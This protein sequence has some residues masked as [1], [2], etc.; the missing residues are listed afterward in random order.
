MKRILTVCVMLALAGGV[1]GMAAPVHAQ[2]G[3]DPLV[4]NGDFEQG[5][6]FWTVEQ[7]CT[8]CRLAL[9]GDDASSRVFPV[10][11]RT[12]SGAN[13]SAIG[14]RQTIDADV[15]GVARLILSMDLRVDS[16]SLP[17]SGWWSDQNNGSGE[18]PVKIALAFTD[19][20]GQPFEWS[21]GFLATHD[22]TTALRNYL[23]VPA[24]TWVP[25]ETDILSPFQWMSPRGQ[26]LPRPARL[27]SL[28]IG[29]SGWDFAGAMN[30][31][32]IT[33]LPAAGGGGSED[34]SGGT[35]GTDGDQSGG[36]TSGD[37]SGSGTETQTAGLIVE[38]YP[39]VA[40]LEDSPTHFEFRDRVTA[41]ILAVRSPWREPDL[42]AQ[43]AEVNAV[44]GNWGYQLMP[45]PEQS[46]SY[47]MY[48][49]LYHDSIL[50]PDVTNVWRLA[51]NQAGTDFRLLLDGLTLPST[52]QVLPDTVANVNIASFAYLP[53]VYVGND[54][55]EVTADWEANQFHVLRNGAIIHTITP[56]EFFVEPPVK[57]LWSWQGHWV[58]EV[59]G[60]L[61]I[62]GVSA[63]S[64]LGYDA[65]FAWQLIA[66][67]PFFFFEQD[68]RIGMS[69]AG[70]VQPYQYDEVVHYQCCEPSMFN[71]G[72]NGTMVWFYALRDGMW[73]YVE[74]G[75]YE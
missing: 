41:E 20:Q 44:I 11:E 42:A 48:A 31:V 34:T 38:E 14:L 61:L 57:A 46:A 56:Q 36:G 72:G 75:V 67:E 62:D 17:N 73:Y 54:L 35:G 50:I 71:V 65:I 23:L 39:L 28:W 49:L 51:V 47:P 64:P 18:Y 68:G 52:V 58:L 15:S 74:A 25:L 12:N 6:E 7:P 43:V 55:I 10:W 45:L 16:H 37:Q 69:Y 32:Q 2:D 13:G 27:V 59:E 26:P 30:N 19:A 5:L 1:V 33:A 70:Q 21:F 9:T 22:G 53:P 24:F 66:G 8:D 40:A 3:G 29:G 60:D 4:R 63:L